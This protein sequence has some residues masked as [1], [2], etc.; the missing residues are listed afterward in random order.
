MSRDIVTRDDLTALA[1]RDDLKQLATRDQ[2][3]ETRDELKKLRHELKKL[4]SKVAT[5][6]E[7][8]AMHAETQR[9]LE[10]MCGMLHQLLASLATSPWPHRGAT[11]PSVSAA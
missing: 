10:G 2:L 7:L 11:A 8:S 1:T 6:D 3:N 5:R 9:T 4:D